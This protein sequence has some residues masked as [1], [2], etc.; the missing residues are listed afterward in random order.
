MMKLVLSLYLLMAFGC[1][2]K[3]KV[4]KSTPNI[5]IIYADD[6]GYGDVSCYNKQ[7]KIS[8]PN[9]D[10][11]AKNGILFTDAHSP[12]GICS[13]SRYGILTG[14]YSW[15]TSRKRGNPKPG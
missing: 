13:P 4:I 2:A 12:S 9:I 15:R 5:I 6:L 11:L 10:K 7:S 8:T 3:K 1:T 14:R